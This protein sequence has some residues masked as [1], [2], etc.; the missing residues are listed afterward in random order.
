MLDKFFIQHLE[1]YNSDPFLSLLVAIY[2]N[3]GYMPDYSPAIP[4]AAKSID[5]NALYLNRLSAFKTNERFQ[6]LLATFLTDPVRSGKYF[7]DAMK[8]ADVAVIALTY[9]SNHWS[10]SLPLVR[11]ELDRAIRSKKPRRWREKWGKNSILPT[12]MARM[13]HNLPKD[14]YRYFIQARP[15]QIFWLD[16]PKTYFNTCKYPWKKE[17]HARGVFRF[18][19][20]HLS[21]ILQ[22][23][24]RS[25]QLLDLAREFAFGSR[26]KTCRKSARKAKKAIDELL[27]IFSDGVNK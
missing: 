5:D 2:L 17:R 22:H 25:E 6:K 27:E 24:G 26:E 14:V 10:Y 20:S 4:K 16:D 13:K 3:R 12:A 7:F 1:M 18:V 21:Y 15:R 23:A 11:S 9:L 8:Y 19:L